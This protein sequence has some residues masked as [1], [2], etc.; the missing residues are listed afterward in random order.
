MRIAKTD[1]IAGLPAAAARDIMKVFGSQELP[2]EYAGEVLAR[3]GIATPADVVVKALADAGYL[4]V[5]NEYRDVEWTTTIQGNALGMAS[6]GK[7][8]SRKTADRLLD[9]L[10][11]RA[12]SYNADPG[13]PMFVRT[14]TIFGSYLDEAV[15]PLGDLDVGLVQ[16]QRTSDD[17]ELR[18]YTRASGRT[19]KTYIDQLFWPQRELFLLLKNR[20]AAINITLEDLSD[21]T[22]RTRIV[23][24]IG[25]DAGAVPPPGEEA[26]SKS[27]SAATM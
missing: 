8:I 18:R 12:R 25:E 21:L 20:S 15:D 14:L 7:P 22:D 19:F 27:P 10:I 2:A 24:S 6:F 11:Q 5:D 16:G 3:Y 23:Y 4:T 1:V 13:K 9:E 17:A 26:S